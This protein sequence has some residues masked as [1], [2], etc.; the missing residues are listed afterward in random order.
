[1]IRQTAGQLTYRF[2]EWQVEPHLNLLTQGAQ[3]IRLEPRT[4]AVLQQ[5]LDR[6]GDLVTIDDLLNQVWAGR[7]VEPGSVQKHITRLR[8]VLQDHPEAPAYIETVKK[9]GYRAIAQIELTGSGD[10][11]SEIQEGRSIAVLPFLNLSD[12]ADQ[13]FFSD[14]LSE[15]I[16]NEL[17]GCANLIVRP[18]SSSFLFK[19]SDE[20]SRSIGRKLNVRHVLEG[21][22]R[23]AG[24]HVRVTAQLIDVDQNRSIWSG[25]YDRELDDVFVIQDTVTAEIF[26]ALSVQLELRPPQREAVDP[27]AYEAF[28]LGRY[29]FNRVSYGEA[30]RWFSHAV[31]LAPDF[32]DAWA[33]RAQVNAYLSGAGF[34]PNIGPNRQLRQSYLQQSLSVDPHNV[35]ALAHRALMDTHYVVRDFQ[36]ALDELARLNRLHPN[37]EDVLISLN[38]VLSTLG[39][40]DLVRLLT[41]HLIRLSPLS[42]SAW[43]IRLASGFLFGPVEQAIVDLS[44]MDRLGLAAPPL[45]TAEASLLQGHRLD[46]TIPKAPGD[47]PPEQYAVSSATEAYLRGDYGEA[48]KTVAPFR[49]RPGY[50]PYFPKIG[51]ALLERNL[52]LAFS[53]LRAAVGEAEQMAIF[54]IQ[55]TVLSR[56]T[57]PEFYTDPRYEELLRDLKL[58]AQSIAAIRIPPLSFLGQ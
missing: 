38:F 14:G 8:K 20:D 9:R 6:Q 12:D 35:T 37:N 30:E 41:A 46:L 45:L 18:R 48:A 54:L 50:V 26:S 56:E 47:W 24:T 31:D 49:D 5:L 22:V 36:A 52:N 33:M 7:I 1:M 2:G 29:H 21:A 13:E 28:L 16:L 25:R 15:D 58:D 55:G 3:K 57:F 19:G 39:K 53:N 42:V 11:K 4:M 40:A 17:A 23:R 34:L 44:E 51:I 32:A 27:K 10:R 43:T